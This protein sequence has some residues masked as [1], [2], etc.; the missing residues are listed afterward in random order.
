[1]N[2]EAATALYSSLNR[3]AQVKLLSRFG[4]NLAVAARDTYEAGTEEL[5]DPP[6]LRR[7][8][9]VQH[10]VFGHIGKLLND[11]PD[12]YPDDVLIS[13][14]LHHDSIALC[15]Q[16]ERAFLEAASYVALAT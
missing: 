3:T 10:H 11:D 6:R 9:E 13:L 7:I 8:N 14:L 16:A 2:A 12:R 1:L 4:F 15:S 5:I